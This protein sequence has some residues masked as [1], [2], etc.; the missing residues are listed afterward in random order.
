MNIDKTI[1]HQIISLRRSI[2]PKFFEA[3]DISNDELLE[4]LEIAKWAPTHKLTQP[5]RFVVFRNAS[6]MQLAV[7]QREALLAGKGESEA[8]LS[9][10]EKIAQ[11][12]QLSA[13]VIAII[14]K[15]DPA[16]RLPEIEEICAVACA[17]QNIA[18]HARSMNIGGYWSTGAS[19]NSPEMRSLLNLS[20]EDVHLGWYYLGRYKAETS[21]AV[22]RREVAEFVELRL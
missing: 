7:A 10:A 14:M 9:K 13:A 4:L 20:S 21:A 2:Y 12:A 22:N 3:D 11:N 15:R 17:V 5:W 6:K 1:S 8:T 16:K 19:T 18:I